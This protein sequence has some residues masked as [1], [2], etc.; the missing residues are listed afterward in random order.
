M[1][2]GD[3]GTVVVT[4]GTTAIGAVDPLDEILALSQKYGFRVHVDAAYG[5][6]FRLI[7]EALDC[8]GPACIRGNRSGGL[9]RDRPA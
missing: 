7:P 5:G 2:K 1:R 9:H 3:V 6:Y 8:A 4:L